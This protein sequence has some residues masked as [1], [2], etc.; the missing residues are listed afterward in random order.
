M[1]RKAENSFIAGLHKYVSCYYEKNNNPYRAGTPDVLYSGIKAPMWVEY[2]F[3]IVPK[4]DDTVITPDLSALQLNWLVK[5]RAE[6]R[7]VAVAV[8]CRE[9]GVLLQDPQEWTGGLPAS[10]FRSR[11]VSRRELAAQ[12]VRV[13][14]PSPSP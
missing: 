11:L 1:T 5:R 8:G 2:K 9:G 10:D 14:G 12:I 6:G 13:T 4:R 7:H 3:I